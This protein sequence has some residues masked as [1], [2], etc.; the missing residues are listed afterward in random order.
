MARRTDAGWQPVRADGL[1]LYRHTTGV[2]V[3]LPVNNLF[4]PVLYRWEWLADLRTA[5]ARV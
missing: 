4:D 5:V 2:Q 3:W 1:R